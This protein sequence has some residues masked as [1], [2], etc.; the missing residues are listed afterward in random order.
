MSYLSFS[1]LLHLVG[2]FLGPFT[3]LQITV[4][5]APSP[6]SPSLTCGPGGS[7]GGLH[8]DLWTLTAVLHQG[9]SKSGF[10]KGERGVL[11]RERGRL[12]NLLLQQG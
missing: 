3:L 1:D 9:G 12:L 11:K 4:H 10:Y 5:P 2:S 6:Q 8:R 7:G